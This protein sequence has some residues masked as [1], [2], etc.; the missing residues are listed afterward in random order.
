[1]VSPS[2][3]C[4][5]F[6]VSGPSATLMLKEFEFFLVIGARHAVGAQQRTALDLEADHR[7]LPVLESE[8]GIAGGGEAEK[9]IGPVPDR[10]NFLSIECAHVFSFFL[11]S[12]CRTISVVRA[13]KCAKIPEIIGDLAF[14]CAKIRV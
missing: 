1:M 14:I 3:I 8:A 7:K 5:S 11:T 13:S 10:K 6:E 4:C 2:L 9:R 12:C